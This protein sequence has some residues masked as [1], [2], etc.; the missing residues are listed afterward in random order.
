MAPSKLKPH[1][2]VRITDENRLD[3]QVWKKFLDNPA[4]YCRPFIDFQ[5][6]SAVEI[7]MYSDASRNFEKGFGAYCGPH[8]CYGQWNLQFMQK[9]KPSIQ[10]LELFGVTVAVINWIHKFKNR[11]IYLFCDNQ[12]VVQMINN[13]SSRCK[14]CMVLIRL[15]TLQGL[16]N[17]TRI[18]AKYVHTLKNDKADA[19]SRLQLTRF[20]KACNQNGDQMDQEMTAIPQEIWPMEKIWLK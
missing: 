7:D 6:Y 1:H 5:P 3:L 13:S 4:V 11:R 17:N 8:W 16:L 14:N 12:S 18:F 20:W 9:Y 2:H 19:L 10:Y 15:I